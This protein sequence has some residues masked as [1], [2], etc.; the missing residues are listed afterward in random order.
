MSPAL[1]SFLVV[2][3][4]IVCPL[5]FAHVAQACTPNC[6]QPSSDGPLRPVMGI[7]L[8]TTYSVVGVMKEGKLHIVPNDQGNSITPSY[9]AL[10]DRGS[11]VGDLAKSAAALDPKN[12]IFDIKRL[13]GRE[14]SDE[15]VQSLIPDFPFQVVE[16]A[17]RP[18]V[19][20]GKQLLTP[21]E[22]SAS[23][24]LKMKDMAEN[25]IG[26][27]I[28]DAVITV[29]AYFNDAQRTAT[30]DA[31]AIA[32]LN[33]LRLV[34][35]PTAASLAYGLGR[36]DDYDQERNVL[37]F[38]LGGGTFDVSILVIDEGVFEVMSTAGN[39]NL[40]GEDFDQRVM[41]HVLANFQKATGATISKSSPGM[42]KLKS[43]VERAKKVLSSETSAT[44]D[45]Q[46]FQKDKLLS[47][48]LTRA[49]FEALNK[50]LFLQTL[51]PVKQA[52]KDAKM[53][54]S[55]IDDIVLVGGSTRIPYVRKMLHDYFGKSPMTNINPDE[56]VAM[57]ATIQGCVI[58]DCPGVQSVL[59]MDVNP[60][61]LG[62]ETDG[63]I[64]APLIKRG[65]SI[66]TNRRQ[67]FSTTVDNQETVRIRV[68]EGELHYTK[69]NNELGEFL[70]SGIPA[71]PK[72]VPQI[73]VEFEVDSNGILQVHAA[74]HGAGISASVTIKDSGL[75]S[76]DEIKRM[77]DTAATQKYVK[78]G[79]TSVPSESAQDKETYG[80]SI[81][82]E[83]GEL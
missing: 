44:I 48:T 12:T 58:M 78:T 79:P 35:E 72:G 53:K 57:G 10:T 28:D 64:M 43:E 20:I 65:T 70:L 56:A 63:G 19:K 25:Y 66:P 34:N 47:E 24:L 71:A 3:M 69:D 22:I 77:I 36:N 62:I 14:F 45:V 11:L 46:E 83:H 55:D 50:D 4:L 75:L 80:G 59:M 51:E 76:A 32:G 21:E 17:G 1:T 5:L 16:Q 60:L 42:S 30:R 81:K 39:T 82:W 41:D 6:G 74:E 68:F 40:G 52:L 54:I 18:A 31:A 61:T 49:K 26:E 23:I 67:V 73:G 15:N 38:D 37:V 7:D 27:H 2:L 9:V 29:P 13:I 8:G 33:V